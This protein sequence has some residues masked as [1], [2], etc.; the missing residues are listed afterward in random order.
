[1]IGTSD[2]IEWN[3]EEYT[4][5]QISIRLDFDEPEAISYPGVD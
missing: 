3:L 4:S 1:V 5:R 2:L